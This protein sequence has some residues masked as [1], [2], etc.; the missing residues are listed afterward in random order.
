MK[1]E[2]TTTIKMGT[3]NGKFEIVNL[4]D[5]FKNKKIKLFD[6]EFYLDCFEDHNQHPE[7]ALWIDNYQ[8]IEDDLY[9][10]INKRIKENVIYQTCDAKFNEYFAKNYNEQDIEDLVLLLQE[11]MSVGL[12]KK[13]VL[14][15][16]I[17]LFDEKI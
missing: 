6:K 10:Y 17:Y 1:L 9:V 15:Q 16:N 4:I 12:I 5:K 11:A 7:K 8:F 2:H 14:I 13:N 3:D